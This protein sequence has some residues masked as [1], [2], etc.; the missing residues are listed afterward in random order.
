MASVF[1]S[2]A[3]EDESIANALR[4]LI[5]EE[6]EP[7]G[8]VFLSSDLKPGD[9]W[10]DKVR[11]ALESC[12]VVLSLLSARSVRRPWINLE[13]GAAWIQKRPIIPVCFGKMAKGSLPQPYSQ[14]QAVVLPGQED[15]L[16]KAVAQHLGKVWSPTSA[17]AELIARFTR[18]PMKRRSLWYKMLD[19]HMKEYKDA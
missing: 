11:A 15:A 18:E 17:D 12:K 6:L 5:E 13:A 3:H 8:A 2:F 4:Y 9:L 7:D 10:M 14:W 16:L 1:I 19:S